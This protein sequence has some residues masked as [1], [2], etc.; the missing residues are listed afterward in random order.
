MFTATALIEALGFI[1]AIL[2]TLSFLP[3]ALR[4]RRQRSAADVSLTMYLMMLTG[5]ALWLIYGVL[6]DSPSLIA[7]NVVG[8]S[9][10]GWVLMMKLADLRRQRQNTAS[11]PV[12]LHR[13][14]PAE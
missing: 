4:I 6:F 11:T 3:Q 12:G 13:P 2:T 10:V 1:A 9:L 14:V 7:A 8:I 5:Q